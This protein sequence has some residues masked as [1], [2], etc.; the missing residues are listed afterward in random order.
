MGGR[1]RLSGVVVLLVVVF[2][3]V[4]WVAHFKPERGCVVAVGAQ[5]GAPRVDVQRGKSR[6]PSSRLLWCYCVALDMLVAER[7]HVGGG[8]GGRI[9]AS[10]FLCCC[11]VDAR[12]A[13]L[14]S[15]QT[16]YCKQVFDP[17]ND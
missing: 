13:S 5:C 15:E 17:A 16:H 10:V 11:R 4:R 8:L 2:M 9:V 12:L 7:G 6:W 14:I 3:E 1:V